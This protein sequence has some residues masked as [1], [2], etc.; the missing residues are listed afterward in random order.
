MSGEPVFEYYIPRFINVT[1]AHYI[2][3]LGYDNVEFKVYCNY[4]AVKATVFYKDQSA[5]CFWPFS[6]LKELHDQQIMLL[7]YNTFSILMHECAEAGNVEGFT[8]QGW[9]LVDE[10]SE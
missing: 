3:G 4:Q 7:V 2:T 9:K 5:S 8:G 10:A 1:L 6:S